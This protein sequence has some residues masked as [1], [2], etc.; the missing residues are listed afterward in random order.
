[1][2]GLSVI[3]HLLVFMDKR[4]Q[5]ERKEKKQKGY[6]NNIKQAIFFFFLSFDN[7]VV[8]ELTRHA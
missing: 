2:V 5:D 8:K 4:E 3:E 6:I 1:M 7:V